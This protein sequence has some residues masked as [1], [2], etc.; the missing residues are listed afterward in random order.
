MGEQQNKWICLAYQDGR[1]HTHCATNVKAGGKEWH[2]VIRI[3][4]TKKKKHIELPETVGYL[5]ALLT[6]SCDY[7]LVFRI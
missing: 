7:R 1:I 5:E 3:F 6:N 4:S 2:P